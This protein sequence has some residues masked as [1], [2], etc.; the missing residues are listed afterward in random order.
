MLI[1]YL[2]TLSKLK[3]ENQMLAMPCTVGSFQNNSWKKGSG[4]IDYLRG[5]EYVTYEFLC[6][7]INE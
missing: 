1:F 2:E 3:Q 4:L 7:Y 6:T 5:S